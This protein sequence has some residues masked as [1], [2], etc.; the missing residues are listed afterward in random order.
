MGGDLFTSLLCQSVWIVLSNSFNRFLTL[1]SVSRVHRSCLF[2]KYGLK[3]GSASAEL[4][5][6]IGEARHL[7]SSVCHHS[8]LTL[9]DQLQC[10]HSHGPSAGE[11]RVCVLQ[12]LLGLCVQ[13]WWGLVSSCLPY[14]LLTG[15]R[16][17]W[18]PLTRF[19]LIARQKKTDSTAVTAPPKKIPLTLHSQT[20]RGAFWEMQFMTAHCTVHIHET[21]TEVEAVIGKHALKCV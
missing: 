9:D 4:G 16:C 18:W 12:A 5:S 20:H 7:P 3:A 14:C 15:W 1:Q 19:G 17:V 21:V 2:I 8:C 13:M 11:A 6:E 10:E